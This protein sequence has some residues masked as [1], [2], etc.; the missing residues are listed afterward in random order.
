MKKGLLLVVCLFFAALALFPAVSAETGQRKIEHPAQQ[1]K[2]PAYESFIENP[3]PDDFELLTPEEQHKFYSDA[4]NVGRC[5]MCDDTYFGDTANIGENPEAEDLFF[6]QAD[7]GSYPESANLYLQRKFNAPSEFDLPAG[8]S[9]TDNPPTIKVGNIVL[10]Q[11]K[12]ATRLGLPSGTNK[13][14]LDSKTGTIV[15]VRDTENV[16]I[17]SAGKK[18]SVNVE[19]DG[20][21]YLEHGAQIFVGEPG[22][23]D[24]YILGEDSYFR[25]TTEGFEIEGHATGVFDG[26]NAFLNLGGKMQVSGLGVSAENG[27][28]LYQGKELTGNFFAAITDGRLESISLKGKDTTLKDSSG[29]MRV[30]DG[31]EATVG[32][33]ED[34]AWTYVTGKNAEVEFGTR[35]S[36][37]SNERRHFFEG[38]FDAEMTGPRHMNELKRVRLL[39][40]EGKYSDRKL[41]IGV[42]HDSETVEIRILEQFEKAPPPPESYFG[43]YGPADYSDFQAPDQTQ[44]LIDEGIARLRSGESIVFLGRNG[45]V[46]S[47]GR[48]GIETVG[49]K[50]SSLDDDTR[51]ER[52]MVGG[53][54]QVFLEGGYSGWTGEY[55]EAAPIAQISKKVQ[56]GTLTDENVEMGTTFDLTATVTQSVI[57]HSVAFTEETARQIADL[58]N[59]PNAL[60][61][62][63]VDLSLEMPPSSGFAIIA[64]PDDPA[65]T[66]TRPRL[67]IGP[68]F[69]IAY[70]PSVRS[71]QAR[72]FGYAGSSPSQVWLAPENV[73]EYLGEDMEQVMRANA[74]ISIGIQRNREGDPTL[75]EQGKSLLSS[76]AGDKTT[77]EGRIASFQMASLYAS[78]QAPD[79][80]RAELI[81]LATEA[82]D[83]AEGQQA[84]LM[85]RRHDTMMLLETAI[86]ANN[87]NYDYWKNHL[88]SRGLWAGKQALEEAA[89]NPFAIAGVVMDTFD[90]L[91]MAEHA[92]GYR[93]SREQ[94]KASQ[95]IS[96]TVMGQGLGLVSYMIQSGQAADIPSA[97]RMID[98]RQ[99]QDPEGILSPPW[100]EAQRSHMFYIDDVVA[101]LTN[102]PIVRQ[103]MDS[104]DDQILLSSTERN[105]MMLDA[106]REYRT[107]GSRTYRETGREHLD[108][109]MRY[110]IRNPTAA[111]MLAK[112]LAETGSGE[113]QQEAQRL[114][115]DMTGGTLEGE[116]IFFDFSDAFIEDGIPRI[117]GGLTNPANLLGYGMAIKGARAVLSSTR[118]GQRV[119]T[120]ASAVRGPAERTL[121]G[122]I[123]FQAGE[124]AAEFGVGMIDP[125]LEFGL[126]VM[127]GGGPDADWQARQTLRNMDYQTTGKF[128]ALPEQNLAAEALQVD[129]RTLQRIQAGEVE[130]GGNVRALDGGLLVTNPDGMHYFLTSQSELTGNRF[131]DL[132]AARQEFDT[133]LAQAEAESLYQLGTA[134]VVSGQRDYTPTDTSMIGFGLEGPV[135]NFDLTRMS[136]DMRRAADGIRVGQAGESFFAL[137][138]SGAQNR[139]QQ[140]PGDVDFAERVH[141]DAP[142]DEA[143]SI[144]AARLQNSVSR[145]EADPGMLFKEIKT[146]YRLPD[147]S[148]D[149]LRWNAEEIELGYKIMPDGS[150]MGLADAVAGSRFVKIDA[151][152]TQD[153]RFKETTSALTLSY[154]TEDG[155]PMTFGQNRIQLERFQGVFLYGESDLLDRLAP[156]TEDTT[157]EFIQLMDNQVVDYTRPGHEDY[158]K[159][160]KRMFTRAQTEGDLETMNGLAPLFQGRA[161]ALNEVK[162]EAEALVDILGM[163]RAP[164]PEVEAQVAGFQERIELLNP[165]LGPQAEGVLDSA[166]RAIRQGDA[167]AARGY[168]N[169]L[170]TDVLSPSIQA[171]ARAH[172]NDMLPSDKNLVYQ[173]RVRSADEVQGLEPLRALA[174]SEDAPDFV[175]HGSEYMHTTLYFAGKTGR[176]LEGSGVSNVDLLGMGAVVEGRDTVTINDYLRGSEADIAGVTV[177]GNSVVLELDSPQIREANRRIYESMRS[178]LEAQGLP[179]EQINRYIDQ[180]SAPENYRPHISVGEFTDRSVNKG[181]FM[182]L[183]SR[184]SSQGTLTAEDITGI[185]VETDSPQTMANQLNAIFSTVQ[186]IQASGR[187]KF[188]GGGIAVYDKER[189]TYYLTG[190]Q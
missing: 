44:D 151:F 86:Q 42:T 138:G 69:G 137:G 118:V 20:T 53:S 27:R 72:Y 37:D 164:L 188:D 179:E 115:E 33:A 59:D 128:L 184:H 116:E 190:G 48:T 114:F 66:W 4:E 30:R 104:Q 150:Q 40:Q 5:G 154:T 106:L 173:A 58:R 38:N 16:F 117:V 109:H 3:S 162:G 18:L 23:G 11:E 171:D 39:T 120:A 113:V 50:Y 146:E 56:L 129:A 51:F 10:Q 2:I 189:G 55:Y 172:L 178:R 161:A 63:G 183:H 36:A 60:A 46:T 78:A 186:D 62:L 133:A 22:K 97:V 123:A 32:F 79:R 80:A 35:L 152:S 29:I 163:E 110:N 111:I 71:D 126:M 168:L 45:D 185:G 90:P 167:D 107:G 148:V 100:T 81:S 74:M 139:V 124:E 12:T 165:E 170:Q 34:G 121:L 93:G 75:L 49:L 153:G 7:L 52:S 180:Y 1:E 26:T 82:P 21:L 101:R 105:Q 61:F 182:D 28:I 15:F 87:I 125:S 136:G 17:S 158:L 43:I 76:L 65:P 157:R 143:A 19:Y 149:R 47:Y 88:Q 73:Q 127:L 77:R 103:A 98:N 112:H 122:S 132:T 41:D 64:D 25:L 92:R 6:V 84:A 174:G 155:I 142:H 95:Y 160:A 175:V 181:Q 135:Q 83:T 91:E 99:F 70:T 108:P 119:L 141:I 85:V 9:F 144:I 169:D 177:L 24:K 54:E 31:G 89:G 102:D 147:G 14:V 131:G 176:R 67:E 156:V 159:T 13:V 130:I 68:N 57:G 166:L 187:I 140:F 8:T 134:S 94:V 145:M 96:Q